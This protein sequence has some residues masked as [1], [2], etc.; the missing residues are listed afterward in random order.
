MDRPEGIDVLQPVLVPPHVLVAEVDT[1]APAN[2]DRARARLLQIVHDKLR[3]LHWRIS[4]LRKR[5]IEGHC[6]RVR[7]L[8]E[9]VSLDTALGK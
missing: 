6:E 7:P 5:A 9:A 3:P 2:E 1:G 8:R 4:K